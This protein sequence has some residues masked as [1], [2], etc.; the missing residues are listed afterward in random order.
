[1]SRTYACMSL[2]PSLPL[3]LHRLQTAHT[4][5]GT[6]WI[7]IDLL[8]IILPCSPYIL[9]DP[10][11]IFFPRST[12]LVLIFPHPW[13]VHHNLAPPLGPL[14]DPTF[15]GARSIFSFKLLGR[16]VRENGRR[17]GKNNW[18]FATLHQAQN[19]TKPWG[20]HGS[21]LPYSHCGA[22]P[23]ESVPCRAFSTKLN[24]K[25]RNH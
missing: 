13:R 14:G 6:K 11:V 21:Q 22:N 18:I 24:K 9:W 4:Y 10:S 3:S 15:K 5:V 1:M 20:L 12:R 19:Q 23:R 8:Y 25:F 2:S 16:M 17:T 7:C